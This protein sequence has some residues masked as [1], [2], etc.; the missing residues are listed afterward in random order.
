MTSHVPRQSVYFSANASQ[1]QL[2]SIH[3]SLQRTQL[4]RETVRNPD[5]ISKCLQKL[6][7]TNAQLA[8]YTGDFDR[9]HTVLSN[10]RVCIQPVSYTHLTL[11]TKA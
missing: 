1:N 9:I 8:H 6:A 4:A 5:T 11:P 2:N 7:E 3:A 10:K